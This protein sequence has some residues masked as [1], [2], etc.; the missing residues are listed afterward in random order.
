MEKKTLTR[1]IS[2]LVGVILLLVMGCEFDELSRVAGSEGDPNPINIPLLRVEYDEKATTYAFHWPGNMIH[3][4]GLGKTAEDDDALFLKDY[5][6]VHKQMDIDEDGYFSFESENIEGNENIRMPEEIWDQTANIRPAQDPGTISTVR[7]VTSNGTVQRIG[8]NGEIISSTSY[9]PEGYRIDPALLDSM[10]TS[11]CDTCLEKVSNSIVSMRQSG[12]EFN[13]VD[14]FHAKIVTQINDEPVFSKVVRVVD[15]R[16]GLA[17][18]VAMYRDDGRFD[19][20]SLIQYSII[21][22]YPVRSKVTTYRFGDVNN[23][24]QAKTVKYIDRHNIIVTRS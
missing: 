10:Y 17:K 7:M 13:M 2:L 12:T 21:S 5:Q 4:D 3:K 8:T 15:L 19:S 9:D 6:Y 14:E 22:G 11:E 16:T 1:L 24:W 23:N 18:K 20:I